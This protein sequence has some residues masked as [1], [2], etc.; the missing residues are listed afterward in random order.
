MNRL[1]SLATHHRYFVTLNPQETLDSDKVIGEWSY[2]HPQF[3]QAAV[4][5]QS[6]LGPLQGQR[7][8]AFCGSYHRY[9]FHEDAVMAAVS[10]AGSLGVVW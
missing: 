1:Q 9:G 6:L 2:R 3:D 8:T 4:A 7:Q 5:S 10:A